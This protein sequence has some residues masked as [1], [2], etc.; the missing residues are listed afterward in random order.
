VTESDQ[1][2]RAPDPTFPPFGSNSKVARCVS[3]QPM[4]TV[5]NKGG[6]EKPAASPGG[7]VTAGT[8]RSMSLGPGRSSAGGRNDNEG[9]L[10][11]MTF[12]FQ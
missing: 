11:G 8:Q 5:L 10:S 2:T 7:K 4:Q 6:V 1:P 9:Q 12:F 3:G